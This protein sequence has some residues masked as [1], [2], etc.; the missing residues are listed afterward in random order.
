MLEA[1]YK[2]KG[3]VKFIITVVNFSKKYKD[4]VS[5]HVFAMLE[6]R[7]KNKGFVNFI[8]KLISRIAICLMKC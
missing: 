3:F 2:N 6:A 1:R 4:F 7:C 5:G 8:F